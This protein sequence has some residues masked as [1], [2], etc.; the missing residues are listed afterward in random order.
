MTHSIDN[1]S[2]VPCRIANGDSL[3]CFNL[4][5]CRVTEGRAG[6]IERV[7]VDRRIPILA[8]PGAEN[9]LSDRVSEVQVQRKIIPTAKKL[10]TSTFRV[11]PCIPKRLFT[12]S[13]V[14]GFES[15]ASTSFTAVMT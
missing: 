9:S 15:K 11:R 6:I 1:R 10:V 4:L 13:F 14:A 12:L 5:V 3:E 8:L 7:T 2:E